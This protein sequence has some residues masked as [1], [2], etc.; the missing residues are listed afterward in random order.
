[1]EFCDKQKLKIILAGGTEAWKEKDLLRSK[2]VPVILRRR[3]AN[4]PK[5]TMPTT[6]C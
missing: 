1:V 5:K 4:L 6:V 2:S 3:W